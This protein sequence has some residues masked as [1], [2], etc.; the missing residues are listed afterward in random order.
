VAADRAPEDA[1]E[2]GI[3]IAHH[4]SAASVPYALG[5]ALALGAHGV[6]RG[7]LDVDV[8]V[9]VSRTEL[10]G[11]IGHLTAL[12]VELDEGASLARADRDGMFVGSWAGIRVDVFVPSIPFS[13]EAARTRVL[14]EDPSG[15]AIWFLSPEALAVFKLLFFRRKDL[16]DLERLIAVSAGRLNTD[17]VR[18]WIVDMMGD[19]DE[20][21]GAWD[22]IVRRF[23][24]TGTSR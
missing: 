6:P 7:T 16:A 5:G 22:D 8:N 13:E 20:R 2:A 1:A 3:R 9:F 18:R 19:D 12:G 4:L 14:L 11:V 15:E 21:V 23:P 24:V 17:Y 10:P